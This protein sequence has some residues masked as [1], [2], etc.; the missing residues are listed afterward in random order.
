MRENYVSKMKAFS[1]TVDD[2]FFFIVRRSEETKAQGEQQ[3]Q[4]LRTLIRYVPRLPQK[5]QEGLTHDYCTH[6][7]TLIMSHTHTHQ[8]K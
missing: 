7:M 6:F 4:A 3:Q 8:K 2:V 5:W 1:K